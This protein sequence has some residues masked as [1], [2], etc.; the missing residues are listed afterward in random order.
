MIDTVFLSENLEDIN[1][2]AWELLQSGI[3]SYKA[4][5]HNGTFCNVQN[6]CPT[7][8]T[9]VIRNVDVQQRQIVFHTDVRSPKIEMLNVSKNIS[10]L[11]YDESLRLQ[12]RMQGIAQVHTTGAT[13]Q[14]SWNAAKTSSQLTYS[15]PHA[16]GKLLTSP[17]LINLNDKN[18]SEE[19]LLLARKNFAIVVTTIS[20]LDVVF[21]HYTGN[22][23][24]I[25]NY[26]NDTACW[27]QA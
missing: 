17:S 25:F 3:T 5:F 6:G 8:R 7:A 22:R 13:L 15:V 4:P 18:P 24:A 14:Q 10:W 26:E 2:K 21:L 9:V 23:R 16:P 1:A 27:A 11:F 12:L 19:T 20:L